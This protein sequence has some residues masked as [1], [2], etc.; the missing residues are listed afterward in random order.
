MPRMIFVNLPVADL[1]RSIA[2]Y[3][4]LGAD[5][6]MQFSDATAAMMSFSTEI[7][8]ML[9]THDKYR[10]FTSKPIAD[11]HASSQV[12]LCLS[13]EGRDEVDATIG[14][15]A[16]AGGVADPSPTQDYGWCYGRDFEDPDGHHWEVMWMD[17]AAATQA[18]AGE[19]AAA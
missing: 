13:A 17:V 1:D 11:A 9:L 2:F 8:V 7:N 16:S 12:L 5:Q 3:R 19:P 18:M 4:A 14:K 15:A 10:Q 6:N